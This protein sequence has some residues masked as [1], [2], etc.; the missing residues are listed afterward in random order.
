MK[1]VFAAFFSLTLLGELFTAHSATV[2]SRCPEMP[3]LKKLMGTPLDTEECHK[4]WGKMVCLG[5]KVSIPEG[6]SEAPNSNVNL[7]KEPHSFCDP[8]IWHY[9]NQYQFE[10]PDKFNQLDKE[11]GRQWRVEEA[12]RQFKK[13]DE[14]FSDLELT[15]FK[16]RQRYRWFR[17]GKT[18]GPVDTGEERSLTKDEAVSAV[19][20]LI[21][22]THKAKEDHLI[23]GGTLYKQYYDLMRKLVDTAPLKNYYKLETTVTD[24]PLLTNMRDVAAKAYWAPDKNGE[25][26]PADF[27]KRAYYSIDRTQGHKFAKIQNDAENLLRLT[28]RKLRDSAKALLKVEQLP[29][30]FTVAKY[31]EFLEKTDPSEVDRNLSDP[32]VN[33]ATA[34]M[35]ALAG[36]LT[37]SIKAGVTDK[38]LHQIFDGVAGKDG[39]EFTPDDKGF[40]KWR[41]SQG[42]KKAE[43]QVLAKLN[44]QIGKV[45]SESGNL[46]YKDADGQTIGPDGSLEV[47]DPSTLDDKTKT[48]WV[49]KI[50]ENI[51]K[52]EKSKAKLEAALQAGREALAAENLEKM[53]PSAAAGPAGLPFE[54]YTQEELREKGIAA[55]AEAAAEKRAALTAARQKCVDAYQLD[56]SKSQEYEKC[57]A[58]V[59]SGA[60]AASTRLAAHLAQIEADSTVLFKKSLLPK[61]K[62]V[63]KEHE[64]NLAELK[65]DLKNHE[66]LKDYT[67]E[68]SPVQ[69]AE[70]YETNWVDRAGNAPAKFDANA[71]AFRTYFQGDGKRSILNP[72]RYIV[73]PFEE[74]V[75]SQMADWVRS[76]ETTKKKPD[77]EP[78]ESEGGQ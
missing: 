73:D 21:A 10:Q 19:K 9:L 63:R 6:I 42:G 27:S 54:P 26:A 66:K 77:P 23:V 14:T 12:E 17:E 3:A 69:L 24:E 43:A 72:M 78:A 15:Y 61:A 33:E 28:N 30:D 53:H 51:L 68:L 57:L 1:T 38:L 46:L 25:S 45:Y 70:F 4:Q 16:I 22:E 5:S 29:D 37:E 36:K 76:F 47:K 18:K 32:K 75:L 74:Y 13:M 55:K 67:F 31:I 62:A 35:E 58:D 71:R 7:D 40:A 39:S 50:V 11:L 41:D 65:T 60:A 44:D 34:Q 52:G 20:E 2:K 64:E 59:A 49:D 48:A 56:T 8:T